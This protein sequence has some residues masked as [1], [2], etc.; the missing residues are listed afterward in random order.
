MCS[1][2]ALH[3][4]GHK[5]CH[6]VVCLLCGINGFLLV[7]C[8]MLRASMKAELSSLD[9]WKVLPFFIISICT[10]LLCSNLVH[11]YLKF[12]ILN[13]LLKEEYLILVMVLCLDLLD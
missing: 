10:F 11:Y 13:M 4:G 5:K 2:N 12:S 6:L 9:H 1:C 8:L 7:S 3:E